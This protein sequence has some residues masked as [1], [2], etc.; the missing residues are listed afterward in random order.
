VIPKVML[1]KRGHVIDL[2]DHD[3]RLE[4]GKTYY[5]DGTTIFDVY[6]SHGIACGWLEETARRLDTI[7]VSARRR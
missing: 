7:V 4:E 5:N 1:V 2:E 6:I 3:V